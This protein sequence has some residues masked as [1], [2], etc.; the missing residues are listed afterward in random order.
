MTMGA[1]RRPSSKTCRPTQDG[2]F[3]VALGPGCDRAIGDEA[4]VEVAVRLEGAALLLS[5]ALT[6]G[7]FELAHAAGGA[8]AL[9]D[10]AR[11]WLR[12]AP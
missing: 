7:D 2:P 11:L 6:L 1:R 3:S 10:R 8:L 5:N 4:L 9:I 12:V